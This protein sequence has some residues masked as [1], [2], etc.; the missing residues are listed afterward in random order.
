MVARQNTSRKTKIT[1]GSLYCN[2]LPY[3][4]K[5]TQIKGEKQ[6]LDAKRHPK[7]LVFSRRGYHADYISKKQGDSK[8]VIIIAD[9]HNTAG[10][11]KE[12]LK[13][14][15]IWCIDIS[16]TPEQLSRQLIFFYPK[17]IQ[18]VTL[19]LSQFEGGPFSNFSEMLVNPSILPRYT[20]MPMFSPSLIQRGTRTV[21]IM[22]L[23]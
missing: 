10:R 23:L 20:T 1:E 11:A 19:V 9:F 13:D 18:C 21:G 14:S 7:G 6:K 16:D 4:E 17:V 22:A 2:T 12:F 5:K 8:N 15:N 3:C